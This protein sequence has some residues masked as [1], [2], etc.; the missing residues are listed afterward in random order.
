MWERGLDIRYLGGLFLFSAVM[1]LS[2]ILGNPD[3][4]LQVFCTRPG[5]ILG[6]L[7]KLQSPFF[8]VLIGY[9]FLRL[10][11]WGLSA[12]LVYASYGL[13][14]ALANFA[15]EGYGRIRMVFFLTLLVFTL[16]VFMR[17]KCFG[18]KSQ[19]GLS[20]A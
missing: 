8:H 7:T 18:Q 1:D 19:E 5:G 9:G 16:Y 10:V 3:Y 2:I 17:R 14:N 12:Y 15:C 4:Q 6:L 20:R 11:R 13:M